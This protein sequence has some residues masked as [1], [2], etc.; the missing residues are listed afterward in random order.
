MAGAIPWIGSSL[1][2]WWW[3]R[4]ERARLIIPPVGGIGGSH[5]P[6]ATN[7]SEGRVLEMA[8][9]I[10]WIGPSSCTTGHHVGT[11]YV[12][13]PSPLTVATIPPVGSPF[14]FQF[15]ERTP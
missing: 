4:A 2:I 8:G 14:E 10:P 6:R 3:D 9:A 15:A 1:H 5:P 7:F 11:K 12:S 13:M